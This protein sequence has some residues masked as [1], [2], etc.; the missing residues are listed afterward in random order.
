MPEVQSKSDIKPKINKL[1]DYLIILDGVG[2]V[3]FFL[4][5]NFSVNKLFM[6]C[7]GFILMDIIILV[8]G[9]AALNLWVKII[10]KR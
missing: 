6:L 1:I 5:N 9:I 8:L 2:I 4:N 10:N 3:V 7:A